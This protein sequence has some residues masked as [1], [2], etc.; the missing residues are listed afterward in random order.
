M[1]YR[2]CGTMNGTKARILQVGLLW[3]QLPPSLTFS[4]IR[5]SSI[6]NCMIE[7]LSFNW[8]SEDE[9]VV[10]TL[11]TLP[12]FIMNQMRA[13]LRSPQCFRVRII[14]LFYRLCLSVHFIIRLLLAIFQMDEV[15]YYRL[16]NSL[17]M[18]LD[19]DARR[20]WKRFSISLSLVIHLTV[21][22]FIKFMHEIPEIP[23]MFLKVWNNRRT[24]TSFK[25][26]RKLL[27]IC[28]GCCNLLPY[29]SFHQTWMA[30]APQ[31]SAAISLS[32]YMDGNSIPLAVPKPFGTC[33]SV[34]VVRCTLPVYLLKF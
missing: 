24:F 18:W 15:S 12:K 6:I 13:S 19:C 14:Y 17:Q 25:S 23:S 8:R 26:S 29:F 20:Y 28:C 1:S 5:P 22:N 34:P 2:H 10:V 27:V 16:H 9:Y 11:I 7:R 33:C 21:I 32:W 4:E 31:N 3:W 30:F